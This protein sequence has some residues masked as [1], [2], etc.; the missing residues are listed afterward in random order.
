LRAGVGLQAACRYADMQHMGRDMAGTP[1]GHATLIR[2]GP[3]T[4]AR[5]AVSR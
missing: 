2:Y 5:S 1:N 3:N 4:M